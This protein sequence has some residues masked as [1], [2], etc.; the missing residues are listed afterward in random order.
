[1]YESV[2]FDGDRM[3]VLRQLVAGDPG[4][5]KRGNRGDGEGKKTPTPTVTIV[6]RGPSVDDLK[7]LEFATDDGIILIRTLLNDRRLVPGAGAAELEV[8]KLVDVYG[9]KMKGQQRHVVKRF[10]MALEVIP[11]ILAENAAMG[12]NKGVSRP[13][14]ENE[15][16]D[17]S[18][19]DMAAKPPSDGTLLADSDSPP[20]PIF[21]SLEVKCC[22]IKN[23][24]QAALSVLS[25]DSSVMG[26]G[27][28][29][30]SLTIIFDRAT[31]SNV[32]M[33]L[34]GMMFSIMGTVFAIYKGRDVVSLFSRYFR[35]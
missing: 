35:K 17:P 28:P 1:M 20:Y 18:D 4:F 19:G 2:E 15:A 6:L 8:A 30:L 27:L 23:A 3:T 31:L 32:I 7:H 5:E 24:I 12:E 14:G 10:A 34:S 13:L 25:L 26:R 16:T 22:A 29:P 9:D 21:D 33:F 11:R